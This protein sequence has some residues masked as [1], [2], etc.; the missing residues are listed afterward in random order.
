VRVRNGWTAAARL[1]WERKSHEER[2]GRVLG[3][4]FKS[5]EVQRLRWTAYPS[6][7]RGDEIEVRAEEDNAVCACP[8]WRTLCLGDCADCEYEERQGAKY[9]HASSAMG[10]KAVSEDALEV[11]L[12]PSQ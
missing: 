10:K 8:V 2:S 1:D 11:R 5:V 6:G 9:V 7:W 4:C 3:G 12:H